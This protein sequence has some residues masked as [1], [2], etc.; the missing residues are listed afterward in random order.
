MA[1]CIEKMSPF[2]PAAI[3]AKPLVRLCL[4][5]EWIPMTPT[6]AARQAQ[7]PADIFR[8]D[9]SLGWLYQFWKRD[10]R[11]R[12]N[13]VKTPKSRPVGPERKW[14]R[15]RRQ[16]QVWNGHEASYG[17]FEARRRESTASRDHGS[18]SVRTARVGSSKMSLGKICEFA[19]NKVPAAHGRT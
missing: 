3:G 5:H 2:L 7:M 6:R 13:R 14:Q 12:V 4:A 15:A 18:A 9:D 11:D 19:L 1:V 8:A 10:E 16:Y 17:I